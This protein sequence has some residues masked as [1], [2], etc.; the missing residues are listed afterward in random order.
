MADD[1]EMIAGEYVLG[2]L[3]AAEHKAFQRRL[4]TD[5][6]AVAAVS[7][8]QDRLSPLLLAVPEATPAPALWNRIEGGSRPA[9][10][11][12]ALR[13]WQAATA[14]AALMAIVSTGMALRPRPQPAT[15]QVAQQT[16]AP[17]F[18]TVAALSEQG[19]A[20]ALLVTYDKASRKMRVMPVNVTPRPGHSLELW[21][22]AGKAAPRSIGLMREG[23]ATALDQ[24]AIDLQ[25]DNT[26]AVSVEPKGGS[27]TGLPTG[28]VIYSGRMI[29]LPIS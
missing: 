24:M 17:L 8:W 19:G 1:I 25:Q 28:P 5:P 3:D 6:D 27:P 26:I 10:D 14:A 15:T 11:N 29:Q 7:G 2:T 4:L 20:P 12:A 22:I 9:N 18:R 21:V 23:G 13:R 16:E